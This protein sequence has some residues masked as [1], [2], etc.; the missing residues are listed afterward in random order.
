MPR[1]IRIEDR[2][3]AQR[4]RGEESRGMSETLRAVPA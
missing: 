2:D 1:K 3:A 4:Q